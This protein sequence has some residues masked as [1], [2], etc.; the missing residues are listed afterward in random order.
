M[1]GCSRAARQRR[2][3]QRLEEQAFPSCPA[4]PLAMLNGRR[5]D[6]QECIVGDQDLV[7]Q[8]KGQTVIVGKSKSDGVGGA[9]AGRLT[10]DVDAEGADEE[11]VGF[12]CA[13]RKGIAFVGRVQERV[14]GWGMC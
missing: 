1:S 11:E 4:R 14:V 6:G 10:P 3:F 2:E 13:L 5:G 7:G 12:R 9:E 8:V